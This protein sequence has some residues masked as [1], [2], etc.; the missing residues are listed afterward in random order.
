[1]KRIVLCVW[2]CLLILSFTACRNK[3]N[4][5]N[6]IILTERIQYPVFIKSP[7]NED[8]DWWCENMEGPKREQFIN[9][10]V[11]AALSGR[12]K[13]HDYI[14]NT[15]LT[16]SEVEGIFNRYDTVLYT[17]TVA[18]FDEV[19]TVINTKLERKDIHRV[20]FL[21]EWY[22][23]EENFIIEKKVVGVAPALTLYDDS[24]EIK[25]FKP[26]FWVYMDDK[27]PLKK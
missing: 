25:G 11:D 16:K 10:I 21:E 6:K 26:L 17:R 23:D 8:T 5:G 4:P 18:P 27:Y 19:D 1:M 3:K 24:G 15:L 7:Y 2:I 20:T 14:D 13:A 9:I 12:V 22:F